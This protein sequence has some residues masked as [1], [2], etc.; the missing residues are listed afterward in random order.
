[1]SNGISAARRFA[2]SSPDDD[3]RPALVG[4]RPVRDTW[5]PY[6]RHDI[7][8]AE[9]RA[10]V[11][12][13]RHGSLTA[14]RGVEQFEE[15]FAAYVG[16]RHAVAVA[17]GTAALHLTLLALGIGP[18]DEVITTPLTFVATAN[19][20]VHTG[21]RPVFADID[22]VTL[23]IDPAAVAHKMT[24]RTRAILPV[25]F[26]GAPCD[27][28]A[29]RQIART[30]GAAI[31]EDAC[32][33]AGAAYRGTPI[34]SGPT[35][36]CFSFH[37][38]K[39]LTTGEG[40]VVTTSRRRL[41]TALRTLRFHGF[42]EDY[43]ARARRGA[44][45]YPL[46]QLLGFKSVLTDMQAAI[47]LVQLGRLA[48]FNERRRALAARYSE[49]FSQCPELE[50]PQPLSAADSSWHIYVLGLRLDRLRCTRDEFMTGLR[51]ENVGAAVH[52]RPVHLQPYYRR[53]YGCSRG[54]LPHAE[55][56]YRR[57]VTLPLYPKM[58]EQDQADVIRAVTRLIRHFRR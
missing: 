4:G 19:A 10:V 35:A 29:L 57:M 41:A 20:I 51:A 28:R 17:T 55:R 37:P 48:G 2:P 33:A 22:P 53:H 26:A 25:H 9:E 15:A 46:M 30:A 40:A 24:P 50:V 6:G 42:R 38:V 52:Y 5:L 32:H 12:V 3:G 8:L 36:Q 47:G 13:L 18:G 1:M 56:A 31:V 7:G 14:G 45:G 16:A 44:L 54:D 39:N 49:A 27:L 58:T 11:E 21:A 34:G 43:T 23:N